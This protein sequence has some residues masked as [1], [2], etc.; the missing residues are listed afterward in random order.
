MELATM[1]Q[2]NDRIA[3]FR[4]MATEDP[5]NELGHFRLGQTL[6]EA[7]LYE[8]AIA[9]FRRTLELEPQFAKVFELMGRCLIQLHKKSEAIEV[10]RQG[11]V[12]AEKGGHNLP[13]EAMA[14]MLIEL[15]KQ[16]P[17]PAGKSVQAAR[18]EAA[19][20][21]CARPGCVAGESAHQLARPPMADE[22]GQR[23]Y[24]HV[25]AECWDYWLR[26][27]SV[28]VI[29]EMRLDLSTDQGQDAYDQIMK[30][31]LGLS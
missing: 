27:L 12:V 24:E 30:E 1:S 8:E 17:A 9:S 25:C 10:L 23:I 5:T 21:H 29:N 31:T 13:R 28:K 6:F 11:I 19:G 22:L 20:F 14:K 16:P 18:G 26:N 4:K 2:L 7:G 3:Q 15:G